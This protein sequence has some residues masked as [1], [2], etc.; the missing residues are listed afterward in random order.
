M[1]I[2]ATA[3]AI[4]KPLKTADFMNECCK[5]RSATFNRESGICSRKDGVSPFFL[6][7]AVDGES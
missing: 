3:V 5:A 7:R 6:V 1:K 4:S 2:S